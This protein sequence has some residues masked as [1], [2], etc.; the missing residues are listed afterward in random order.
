MPK[1]IFYSDEKNVGTEQMF[2][3]VHNLKERGNVR[4]QYFSGVFEYLDGYVDLE[5]LLVQ[6]DCNL[7]VFTTIARAL[8]RNQIFLQNDMHSG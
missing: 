7:E 4:I 1:P 6:T 8:G 5:E 2:A 3:F